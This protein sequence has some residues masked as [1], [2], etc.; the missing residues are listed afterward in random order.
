MVIRPRMF[1]KDV[2]GRDRGREAG[3]QRVRGR[4]GRGGEGGAGAGA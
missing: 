1:W 2:R 3:Q 4:C